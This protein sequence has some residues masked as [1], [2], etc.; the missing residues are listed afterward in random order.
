MTS[1][2]DAPLEPSKEESSNQDAPA[3]SPENSEQNNSTDTM[4]PETSTAPPE[5]PS[6]SIESDTENKAAEDPASSE[7]TVHAPGDAPAD[8]NKEIADN[9]SSTP[10]QASS[11][12]CTESPVNAVSEPPENSGKP[13]EMS[14]L[15]EDLDTEV[16]PE[17]TQGAAD[18]LLKTP[19]AESQPAIPKNAQ[20]DSQLD[21]N[22]DLPEESMVEKPDDGAELSTAGLTPEN[23]SVDNVGNLSE[24]VSEPPKKAPAETVQETAP[25]TAP[26][27]ESPEPVTD[28]NL[29]QAKVESKSE[30]DPVQKPVDVPE[31]VPDQSG[32]LTP[33]GTKEEMPQSTGEVCTEDQPRNSGTEPSVIDNSTEQPTYVEPLDDSAES[34]TKKSDSSGAVLDAPLGPASSNPPADDIEM[35][36]EKE[37]TPALDDLEE[38]PATLIPEEQNEIIQDTPTAA[39]DISAA[40]EDAEVSK[41]KEVI[42]A[43]AQGNGRT[44]RCCDHLLKQIWVD[45]Q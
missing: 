17:T 31:T 21:T 35:T 7:Q 18:E 26:I 4:H 16:H 11:A 5:G 41:N 44:R 20:N 42:L 34:A 27:E 22:A 12:S 15:T 25:E 43:N 14:A 9:S 28:D 6:A 29:N 38:S 10:Q 39:E 33:S 1:G 3:V 37:E 36:V 2:T 30:E 24:P 32:N 40:E 8:T 45:I 13:E 23:L 19:L